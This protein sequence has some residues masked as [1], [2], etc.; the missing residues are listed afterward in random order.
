MKLCPKCQANVE[1][2]IYRCDCCGALLEE[3]KKR[4]F[5]CAIYELPQC[6]GFST[7]TREMI[8]LLQPLSPEKYEAF[9]EE[10]GIRMI[11]YP[12][13]ILTDGN[14]RK[15]L[16]YSQKRKFASLTITVDYKRFIFADM[17]EKA[18]MVATAL[19]QG[20]HSLQIRLKK[21]KLSIDDIVAQAN[22]SLS[23]Y[24]NQFSYKTGDD[25][26]EP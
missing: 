23:K 5:T 7:L 24:I 11:C 13:S 2:L 12:P 8:D 9:I 6:I 10:V 15:R 19:L 22:T 26:R 1:G 14:I 17:E 4:F 21:H 18:S 25:L 20:V 16:Y 3:R